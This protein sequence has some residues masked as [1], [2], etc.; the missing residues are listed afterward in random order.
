MFID[1][2]NDK[3]YDYYDNGYFR[4]H[5]NETDA[6]CKNMDETENKNAISAPIIEP[7]QNHE[8]KNTPEKPFK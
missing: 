6:H 3:F 1:C 8:N 5:I 4:E 2:I 7:F